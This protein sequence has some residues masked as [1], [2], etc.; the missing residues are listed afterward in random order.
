M[1]TISIALACTLVGAIISYLTFQRNKD[2]SIRAETK[3][4]T[5]T[6]AKLDYISKGVD[7][8]KLDFREQGRQINSI[9]DRLIRVE[10]ST[11]SAHKRI[12]DIEKEGI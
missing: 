3:E 4:D 2:N 6:K 5:F 10:E 11:K 8:I 12:N 1:E 9:N 7:D